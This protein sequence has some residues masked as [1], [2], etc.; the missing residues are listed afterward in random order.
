VTPHKYADEIKAAADGAQVQLRALGSTGPWED[1][2]QGDYFPHF[3]P[4]WEWRIK[5]KPVT[6]RYRVALMRSPLPEGVY[7]PKSVQYGTSNVE[8]TER[9]MCFVRWLH[10]WQEVEV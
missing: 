9:S 5:P 8:H 1:W 7:Y 2:K 6:I 4:K 3:S 10:D